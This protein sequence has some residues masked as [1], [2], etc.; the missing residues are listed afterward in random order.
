M[1][2]DVAPDELD[3]L[4]VLGEPQAAAISATDPTTARWPTFR[5]CRISMPPACPA[6]FA[7]TLLHHR[8]LRACSATLRANV[9][10]RVLLFDGLEI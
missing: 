7:R 6:G 5:G 2:C 10:S 9:K 4:D 3:E 8:A 1:A